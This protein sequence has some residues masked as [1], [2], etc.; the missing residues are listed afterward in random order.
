MRAEMR[1]QDTMSERLSEKWRK[2]SHGNPLAEHFADE[3]DARDAVLRSKLYELLALPGRWTVDEI[4]ALNEAL[5]IL[6]GTESSILKKL[7][8]AA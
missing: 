3:L 7:G 5:N 8:G 4:N 2:E 1:G 6:D